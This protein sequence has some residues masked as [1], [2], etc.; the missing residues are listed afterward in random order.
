MANSTHTPLL[1]A[2]LPATGRQQQQQQ[3]QQQQ[4]KPATVLRVA[5]SSRPAFK[6]SAPT[7]AAAASH[8]THQQ[9]QQQQQTHQG[10]R[11]PSHEVQ[12]YVEQLTGLRIKL[13]RVS[14]IVLRERYR[15]LEAV[16]VS[17][18]A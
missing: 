18:A 17:R 8:T 16:P 14:G 3:Q 13:P 4:R 2:C 15:A 5:M 6:A 11:P 12:H 7:A 1:P 10:K 9:Q